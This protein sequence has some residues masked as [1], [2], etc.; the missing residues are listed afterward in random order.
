MAELMTGFMYQNGYG[1]EQSYSL[2]SQWYQKAAAQNEVD[3]QYALGIYYQH[4][5]GVEENQSIAKSYY[6]QACDNGH[7][8][9]CNYYKILEEKGVPDI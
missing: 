8:S 9:G 3:A 5:L 1:V 2:A 7:Q 4:G 6:R